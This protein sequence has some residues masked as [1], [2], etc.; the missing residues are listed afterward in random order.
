MASG[1][2]DPAEST[3]ECGSINLCGVLIEAPGK[4][5]LMELFRRTKAGEPTQVCD[6]IGVCGSPRA[7]AY[8]ALDKL[9]SHALVNVAASGRRFRRVELSQKAFCAIQERITDLR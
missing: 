7:K 6:I 1:S 3:A 2:Q 4:A 8:K 5:M 9:L